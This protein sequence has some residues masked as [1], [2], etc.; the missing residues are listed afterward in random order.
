MRIKYIWLFVAAC[1][2]VSCDKSKNKDP[3]TTPAVEKPAF[4]A[5]SAFAFV[6]AQTD[7]GPRTPGSEAHSS[8]AAY[9]KEQL[10]AFAIL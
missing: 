7:F 9:L 2:L 1:L 8:C 5:D 10:A 4:D 3:E 6:K